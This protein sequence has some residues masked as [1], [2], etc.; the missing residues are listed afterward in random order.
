MP[1]SSFKYWLQFSKPQDLCSF[2][3]ELKDCIKVSQK[4]AS[5]PFWFFDTKRSSRTMPV[6]GNQKLMQI[7][8]F[9]FFNFNCIIDI[10]ERRLIN[11]IPWMEIK[12]W[13]LV[14]FEQQVQKEHSIWICDTSGY[15]SGYNEQNKPMWKVI[16]CLECVAML[17]QHE[18]WANNNNNNTSQ[19]DWSEMCL[20]CRVGPFWSGV[21]QSGLVWSIVSQSVSQPVWT[22]H[23]FC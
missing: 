15:F 4:V 5:F 16:N 23:L 14:L 9:N 13:S 21:S 17:G 8:E 1:W 3:L 22:P 2:Y 7:Y 6:P 12:P 20:N 19:E 11:D 10:Q 18:N